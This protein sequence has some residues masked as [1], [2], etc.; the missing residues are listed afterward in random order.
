MIELQSEEIAGMKLELYVLRF[1]KE[2]MTLRV[3]VN[4]VE[5][6]GM[7]KLSSDKTLREALDTLRDLPCE[8]HAAHPA[9]GEAA[10]IV[11]QHKA[12]LAVKPGDLESLT[13]ALRVL[14]AEPALRCTLGQN[15][16]VA[17][18]QYFDRA[19]IAERFIDYLEAKAN[20]AG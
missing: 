11:Q 10:E 14:K 1:E 2:R 13:K 7:R 8:P 19:K 4:K 6:I 20:P 12:G 17:A 5:A 16:R 3:P 9:D 15:G 18:E